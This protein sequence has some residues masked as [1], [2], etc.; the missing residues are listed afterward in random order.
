MSKPACRILDRDGRQSSSYRLYQ[1]SAHACAL[2]A[3]EGLDLTLHGFSEEGKSLRLIEHSLA[4]DDPEPKAISCYG[5]YV[6]HFKETWVRLV[7]GRPISAITT[8]FLSWCSEKLY[9]RGKKVWVLIWDNAP[10]H[11]SKQARC[12]IKEHNHKVKKGTLEGVRIISCYLPTKSPW[13]NAMEPK[14]IHGKRKVVEADRLL[15]AHELAERDC[16]AFERPHTSIYPSPKMS[17]D[18]AVWKHLHI[19][20]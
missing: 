15:G 3:H 10:W 16:A 6:P 11:V 20:R 12:W 2:L 8:Q 1:C 18:H 5:L 14:W 19:G 13:L 7:G 4:K 9:G 17:L